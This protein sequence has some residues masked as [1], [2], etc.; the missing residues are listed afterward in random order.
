[1]GITTKSDEEPF[2]ITGYTRAKTKFHKLKDKMAVLLQIM[3]LW[4]R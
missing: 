4:K 3:K 1:M 2:L